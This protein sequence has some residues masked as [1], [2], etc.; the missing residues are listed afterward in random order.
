MLSRGVSVLLIVSAVLVAARVPIALSA[1]FYSKSPVPY[2]HLPCGDNGERDYADPRDLDEEIR[3][4]LKN[5]RIQHELML[6]DYLSKDYEF[7]YESV[8]IGVH[9]HQ[10]IPNWLPGKKDVHSVKKLAHIKPQLLVKYLPKLHT[11]LQKFA[12]ALEEM[13]ED[14]GSKVQDALLTTQSYL[15]MMICEVETS[16]VSLP[17]L[18]LPD[19]VERSIMSDADRQPVDDTRRL[20]RDW[21]IL[22]K[23][24]DYIHAWRHAFNY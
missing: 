15:K 20:V 10:Y 5:L 16:I 1:P 8:R 7:L 4:S 9:E 19:R 6:N 23:Y 21:G 11:D 18:H 13:V 12:V 3:T 24:K 14:E 22:V 2:W 17:M